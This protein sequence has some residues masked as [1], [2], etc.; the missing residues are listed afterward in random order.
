[1]HKNTL[2]YP[3]EKIQMKPNSKSKMIY[4]KYYKKYFNG[5]KKYFHLNYDSMNP[6]AVWMN[7][8]PFILNTLNHFFNEEIESSHLDQEMKKDLKQIYS[9]DIFEYRNKFA[10]VTALLAL[11]LHFKDE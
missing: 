5:A 11:K 2:D 6:Y 3:W 1:H 9:Q 4:G 7:K 8:Y 10:V